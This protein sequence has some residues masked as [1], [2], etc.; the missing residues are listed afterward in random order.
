MELY[1]ELQE[2]NR[3]IRQLRRVKKLVKENLKTTESVETFDFERIFK[4][5]EIVKLVDIAKGKGT[6]EERK[7]EYKCFCNRYGTE[8]V[9]KFLKKFERKIS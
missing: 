4:V 2:K 6:L 5:E 7:K 3:L 9:D 1:K 8:A